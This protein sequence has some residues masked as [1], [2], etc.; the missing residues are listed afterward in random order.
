MTP[1]TIGCYEKIDAVTQ[2]IPIAHITRDPVL[3]SRVKVD[4]HTVQDYAEV[5]RE[6]KKFPPIEVFEIAGQFLLVDGYHRL[7]AA[8]RN[9]WADIVCVV[10]SGTMRDAILWACGVN[11]AHG[12]RR[13]P[14]DKRQSVNRLL[15]DP[16][17]RQWT[18]VKIANVC[19]V[20]EHLV[21]SLRPGRGET[22]SQQRK[23][24]TKHG[25]PAKMDITHIGRH[26]TKHQ[27]PVN[28]TGE[29][30]SSYV[31]MQPEKLADIL[32]QKSL[33]ESQ[34]KFLN[35]VIERGEAETHLEAIIKVIDWAREQ[36]EMM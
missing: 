36:M 15:D 8:Q 30:P 13:T 19:N 35:Q 20:S 10:H 25:T 2:T 26:T 29:K 9:K 5:M 22:A 16:E 14:E 24:V 28:L 21:R 1:S 18:N 6:G 27:Q 11:D 4:T 7:A 17:W 12:L 31:E 32:V 23:Y 33:S 3:Q 34:R